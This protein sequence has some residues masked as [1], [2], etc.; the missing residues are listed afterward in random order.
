MIVFS[1]LVPHSP[2]LAPRVGREKRDAL[3]A[4]LKAY[5]ELEQALYLAK[6]ETVAMISPHAPSYPDAFSANMAPKYTGDLKSFGDHETKMEAKGDFLL[7]DRLQRELRS[8]G[9]PF[10]LTSSEELDYGFTV[11]LLLLTPHLKDW[12]LVPLAPSMLDAQAHADFGR[13]LKSV[14][15]RETA[16]VAFIASADL[17]HKLDTKSP[18]GA[19]VEGPAFDATLRSKLSALDLPGLLQLDAQAVEAAG[20][21]GYRPI[22]TLLG[23]LEGLNVKATE[24]AYEAPFGVGYLTMRFD[25]A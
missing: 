14:L 21:C 13:R 11:P 18:G 3:A 12:R 9:A 1:A 15:H 23:V 25:L 5:E 22:M 19:S 8:E 4:T 17:S 7:L 10:T 24:L 20:Q 6:V 16:R 2:L